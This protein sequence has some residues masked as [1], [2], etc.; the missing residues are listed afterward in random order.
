MVF[1][2]LLGAYLFGVAIGGLV[3]HDLARRIKRDR[4]EY[5]R[6]ISCFVVVANLIGYSVAWAMSLACANALR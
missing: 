2:C 4:D 5:L 3:A 1:A 6:L